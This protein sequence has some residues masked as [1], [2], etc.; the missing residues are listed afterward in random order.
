MKKFTIIIVLALLLTACQPGRVY[1]PP[2]TPTSTVTNTPTPTSTPLPTLAPTST[3]TPIPIEGKL[4]FDMNGSGL[5]DEATFNYDSKRL[6]DERQP[7][8]PDLLKV[9]TEYVSLNSDLRDGD[10][11][12]I[13]EPGL[14]GFT[15]CIGDNCTKTDATG[16]FILRE[17]TPDAKLTITDPNEGNPAL[18][19]RFINQWINQVKINEKTSSNI[20]INEQLLNNTKIFSILGGIPLTLGR[21]Y[22]L[23]LSQGFLTIPF[24][25]ST[26]FFTYNWIDLNPDVDQVVNYLGLTRLAKSRID[27][28]NSPLAIGDGHDAID[29]AIS[30]GTVVYAAAPGIVQ[31]IYQLS[32]GNGGLQVRVEIENQDITINYGHMAFFFVKNGDFVYRGQAIAATGPVNELHFQLLTKSKNEPCRYFGY[33]TRPDDYHP[34]NYQRLDPYRDVNNVNC[35]SYWSSDN[36]PVFSNETKKT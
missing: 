9:I 7:L 26:K 13:K 32:E 3:S 14:S 10:L 19:M 33:P 22:S 1:G 21:Y 8:Q 11:I 30:F 36:N 23:G 31:N 5:Q 34:D 27:V 20:Y 16:A 29:Y 6:T 25:M 12:T 24:H 35:F 28:L 18:K 15:V 17:T 4:F 2:I